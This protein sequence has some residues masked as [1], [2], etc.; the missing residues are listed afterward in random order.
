MESK[1]HDHWD[2]VIVLDVDAVDVDAVYLL[3]SVKWS[4]IQTSVS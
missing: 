2:A 3:C 4:L 1:A